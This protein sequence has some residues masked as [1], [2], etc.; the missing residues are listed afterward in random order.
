MYDSDRGLK[1]AL[2]EKKTNIEFST[3]RKEKRRLFMFPFLKNSGKF[4]K[5]Q[6]VG[7]YVRYVD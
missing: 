7:R 2:R 5:A 4:E 3:Q 1:T 6:N